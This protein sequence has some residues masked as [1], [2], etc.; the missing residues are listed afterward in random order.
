[1]TLLG[2]EICVSTDYVHN[3]TINSNLTVEDCY[4]DVDNVMIKNNAN[5][6]FDGE[7]SVLING[8]FAAE[9]GTSLEIK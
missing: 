2:K 8:C 7:Y 9:L 3:I 4:I 6:V 5:V 1:M